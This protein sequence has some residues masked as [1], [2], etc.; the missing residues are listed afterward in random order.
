[1]AFLCSYPPAR[2]PADIMKTNSF[3]GGDSTLERISMTQTKNN[4]T[5]AFIIVHHL[6]KAM[7]FLVMSWQL[8]GCIHLK[9]DKKDVAAPG[10]EE[11]LQGELTLIKKYLDDGK[12][13]RAWESLRPLY[14]KHP[15]HPDVLTVAGLTHLVL[16][17]NEKAIRILKKVQRLRP[18]VS[19]GLNL[20]SA[21]IAS[22]QYDKAGAI[23]VRAIR[24]NRS[25]KYKERLWHNLALVREKQKKTKKAIKFYRKALSINPA[26]ILSLN[27]LAA[28]YNRTGRKK[29][30]I[31]YYEK[32]RQVCGVCFQPVRAL[33]R[34]Y[35]NRGSH[36]AAVKVLRDFLRKGTSSLP[37]E[38]KKSAAHLLQL[39]RRIQKRVN[40]N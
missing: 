8:P 21:Y 30:A 2:L 12:A 32:A 38:Q 26:Y 15:E 31:R 9:S 18:R 35:M 3:S 40:K 6:L 7:L 1:M 16:D 39:A 34:I 37:K 11:V 13:S 27:R 24:A 4:Y 23:L 17:N 10:D 29:W 14:R 5:D 19:T 36:G 28:V 33:A 22:G 25:Y 20:S